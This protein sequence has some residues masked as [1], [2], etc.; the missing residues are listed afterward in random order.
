MQIARWTHRPEPDF[1]DRDRFERRL[2]A[3]LV[4][5]IELAHCGGYAPT[6][7]HWRI[8]WRGRHFGALVRAGEA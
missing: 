1:F 6:H 5:S 8:R 7:G 3:E 4:V 2:S